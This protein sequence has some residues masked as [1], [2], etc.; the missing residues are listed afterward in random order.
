MPQAPTTP[1]AAVAGLPTGARIACS[2]GCGTPTTLLRAL[3]AA[4]EGR[5]WELCSGLQLGGYPFLDAVAAGHLGYRTWHVMAPVR[6]LVADGRAHYVPARASEVPRLLDAWDVRV[7]L[8]R[9]SPPDRNGYLSLGPSVSYPLPAVQRAAVVVAEVDPALPRTAGH[10]LLHRSAVDVLVESEDPTPTYVAAE[11]DEVSRR[12]AAHVVDLLPRH[13][14]LQLGIGAV[15]EAITAALAD[16]DVGTARL[17]GM[18]SDAAVDLFARGVLDPGAVVPAPAVVAAEL[19]GTERLFALADGN[20]SI[21]V[22]PSTLS[23]DAAGLGALERFVSVNSAVEVD[24]LGQ[25]NA[26]TVGSRQLSGVGGSLD[27]TEAAFRSTGGRRIVALPSTAARGTAS[28]VVARLDGAT[29]VP[30]AAADVVVT[31]HGV[32]HLRGR[33]LAERDEALRAVAD[34]AHRAALDLPDPAPPAAPPPRP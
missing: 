4:S 15:P 28:R 16:A 1:A 27:Y 10:S 25:V 17:V 13:P 14:V 33:S 5:G 21:G 24:L 20:P 29:T 18:A 8:V 32:A 19:M 9:V 22:Y 3:A 23:H 7:A 11:P 12:I 6:D 31:E 2:P 30:R 34:P 26:E